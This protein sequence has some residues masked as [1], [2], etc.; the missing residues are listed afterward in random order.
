MKKFTLLSLMA[1]AM[2]SLQSCEVIG[3]IFK[4]GMWFGV[5]AV[6]AVIGL[7]VW[8]FGRAKK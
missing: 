5:I 2:F 6:V 3:D 4:T 8:L 1:I 7:I